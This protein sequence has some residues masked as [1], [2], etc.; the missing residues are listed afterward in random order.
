MGERFNSTQI[1]RMV[2]VITLF[3]FMLMLAGVVITFFLRLNV[4]AE[5]SRFFWI[6]CGS[7]VAIH[8]AFA[9]AEGFTVGVREARDPGRPET[10]NPRSRFDQ[11][12]FIGR[13]YLVIWLFVAF[14]TGLALICLVVGVA[15]GFNGAPLMLLLVPLTFCP[16]HN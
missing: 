10:H 16:F 14:L 4:P 9:I 3:A 8:V 7:I 2:R 12:L 5:L 6:A 15:N 1:L 13:A 11:A